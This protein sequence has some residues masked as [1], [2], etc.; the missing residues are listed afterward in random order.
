MPCCPLYILKDVPAHNFWSWNSTK[1]II[2]ADIFVWILSFAVKQIDASDIKKRQLSWLSVTVVCHTFRSKNFLWEVR[3]VSI[4]NY[5][6]SQVYSFYMPS[7]NKQIHTH[8][9]RPFVANTEYFTAVICNSNCRVVSQPDYP[10]CLLYVSNARSLSLSLIKSNNT[11]WIHWMVC[12]H[13]FSLSSWEIVVE[14][15]VIA[16]SRKLTLIV[17]QPLYNS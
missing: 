7:A 11:F 9:L 1:M 4:V 13:Y 5:T 8:T 12:D 16:F 2:C 15:F 10:T 17:R 6:N 3:W 14:Q